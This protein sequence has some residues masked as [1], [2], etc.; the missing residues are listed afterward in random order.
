MCFIMFLICEAMSL[1]HK[2]ETL[3]MS[4]SA[5]EWVDLNAYFARLCCFHWKGRKGTI[6][7]ISFLTRKNHG[8]RRLDRLTTNKLLSDWFHNRCAPKKL[9]PSWYCKGFLLEIKTRQTIVVKLWPQRWQRLGKVLSK[10]WKC[11][12][13]SSSSGGGAGDDTQKIINIFLYFLRFYLDKNKP[14]FM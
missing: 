13:T 10:K 4:V 14:R 9:T 11:F 12:M 1:P 8:Q 3:A 5:S 2:L 7:T 6:I